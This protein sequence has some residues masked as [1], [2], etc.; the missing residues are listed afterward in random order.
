[1]Y[2]TSAMQEPKRVTAIGGIFIK[3]IDPQKTREWY[4]QHLGLNT[5]Q[6]GTRF[7]WL[8][9]DEP[10]RKGYN[11]WSTFP[12]D[13]QYFEPSKKEFM[14][15]L[16]VENLAWLLQELKKEGIEQIGDTQEYEYGKFA[17]IIDPDGT[18]VE[19]WEANDVEYAKMV[20]ANITK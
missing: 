7:E 2:S 16:R 19:L 6:Y 3:C 5:D 14:I 18:K 20:G 13:T 1:M 17:H 4:A 9:A 12:K 15:N 8:H 10:G 11:A